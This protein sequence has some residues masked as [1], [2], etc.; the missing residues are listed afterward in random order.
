MKFNKIRRTYSWV[1]SGHNWSCNSNEACVI[2]LTETF[3]FNDV[4]QNWDLYGYS[5]A[6]CLTVGLLFQ[7]SVSSVAVSLLVSG[8]TVDILNTFCGVFMVQCVPLMLIIFEFGVLGLLFDCFVYLQNVT[9]L[10]SFVR[11][12]HYAGEVQDIIIS[13]LALQLS[14]KSLCQKLELLVLFWWRYT[15]K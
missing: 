8:L 4:L 12:K 13:R 7:P 3:Y 2:P 11:Y 1:Y 5:N 15:K 9:S 10:K 14:L 6:E